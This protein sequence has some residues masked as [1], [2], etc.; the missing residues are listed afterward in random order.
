MK[1]LISFLS[2]AAMVVVLSSSTSISDVSNTAG[3]IEPQGKECKVY[4]DAGV[5]VAEC[6]R[7]NC[8]KLL[9]AR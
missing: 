6:A 4:N 5:L 2:A 7:C 1:K 3:I 9:D 8:A